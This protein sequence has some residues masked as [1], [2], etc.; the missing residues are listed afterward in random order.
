MKIQNTTKSDYFRSSRYK[1]P[2]QR[3]NEL[4]MVPIANETVQRAD[5][6]VVEYD[7]RENP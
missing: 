1:V 6:D 3:L 7:W 2:R 4:V 5:D